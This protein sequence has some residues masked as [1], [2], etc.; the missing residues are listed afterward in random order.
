MTIAACSFQRSWPRALVRTRL[1]KAMCCWRSTIIRSRATTLE[2]F[3]WLLVTLRGSVPRKVARHRALHQLDPQFAILKMFAGA[4]DRIPKSFGRMFV[5][6]KSVAAVQ[7]WIV[8]LDDL[9]DAAGGA[10]DRNGAILKT[11]HRAQAS[12]LKASRNETYVHARFDDVS[13]AL[14]VVALIG[15]L[16]WK[17]SRRD[18]QTRFKGRIAFAENDEPH[19]IGQQSIEKRHQN[20]ESLFL[21]YARDHAENRAGWS[22]R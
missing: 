12:R 2:D 19:V 22:R 14:I 7:R 21:D 1:R 20:L 13:G 4:F 11:V 3:D 5:T 16:S 6:E 10:S 15:E 17:F 18:R 9:V 8:I